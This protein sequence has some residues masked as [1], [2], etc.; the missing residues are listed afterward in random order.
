MDY[1]YVWADGAHVNVRLGEGDRL[2]LLVLIGARPGGT[3]PLLG[4][5]DGYRESKESWQAVLRD[6]KRRGMRAPVL[7]IGDAALG[8]WA[9]VRDV[10]PESREQRDGVHRLANV[11]DKL[12]KRLQ[13]RAKAA[14]REIMYAPDREAAKAGIK[15]FRADYDAKY[16]KAIKSLVRDQEKLP[17]FFDFPAAHWKHIRTANPV[18]STFATVRLR[19]RITTGP[20]SSPRG[21]SPSVWARAG[22]SAA[23]T[24][25]APTKRRP[26]LTGL[27]PG[28]KR[29]AMRSQVTLGAALPTGKPEPRR[30]RAGSPARDPTGGQRARVHTF[31]ARCS[32]LPRNV[33][34]S[35]SATSFRSSQKLRRRT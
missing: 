13:A 31:P 35:E 4:V 6:L 28:R 16:P 9:A 20:G 17:T 19:Q 3:K 27:L 22:P 18:E 12:P 7:A 5:E 29:G 10:W 23:R 15:R 26:S 1:V 25:E 32:H 2:Y 33:I 8:F 14:L 30:A 21:P 11:L 24:A 34:Q